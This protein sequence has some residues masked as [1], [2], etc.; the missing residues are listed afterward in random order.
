MRRRILSGL[1]FV[2]LV[3]VV[4]LMV[5]HRT[6]LSEEDLNRLNVGM[7][8]QEVESVLGRP[9]DLQATWLSVTDPTKGPQGTTYRD[10]RLW[11]CRAGRRHPAGHRYGRGSARRAATQS[12]CN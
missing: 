4:S 2:G 8:L 11:H 5:L 10:V 1:V 6:P 7:T 12:H 9:A 3:F